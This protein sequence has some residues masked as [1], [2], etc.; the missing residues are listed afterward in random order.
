MPEWFIG[1]MWVLLMVGIVIS[2]SFTVIIAISFIQNRLLPW[3]EKGGQ[4]ED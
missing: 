2:V 1:L 4:G 3:I